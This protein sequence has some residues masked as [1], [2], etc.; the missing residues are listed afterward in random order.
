M[1]LVKTGKLLFLFMLTILTKHFK[2]LKPQNRLVD[3]LYLV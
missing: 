1:V 2:L 3:E